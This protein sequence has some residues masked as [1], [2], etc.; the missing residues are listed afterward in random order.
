MSDILWRRDAPSLTAFGREVECSC[1]VRNLENGLRRRDE[2]V[3]STR[4]DG[5]RGV[6]YSPQLFP[7][8][9]W[10]VG[11]PQPESH[12]YLA[13]Y[14]IPTNAHQFV[15]VWEAE[16]LDTLHYLGES[17]EYIDDWAYGLHCSTSLTTL[18]CI[19]IAERDALMLMVTEI[20]ERLRAGDPVTLEVR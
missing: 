5:S 2:V 12:S 9:T 20:N 3:F 16:E 15:H 17:A 11:R 18:G 14:F 7:V 4:K 13:P 19:R 6:P 8:G 1:K 10:N